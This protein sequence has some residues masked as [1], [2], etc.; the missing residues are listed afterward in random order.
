MRQR[1][2][3]IYLILWELQLVSNKKVCHLVSYGLPCSCTLT[4]IVCSNN[5]F[6]MGQL[7][8]L[9]EQK[10]S[11]PPNQVRLR[12]FVPEKTRYLDASRVC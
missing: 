11:D 8:I 9:K 2:S 3:V 7:H 10:E 12:A 5:Q 1:R 4:F 6:T